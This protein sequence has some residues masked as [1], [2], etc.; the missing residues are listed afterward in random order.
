[1]YKI[2]RNN[3][4]YHCDKSELDLIDGCIRNDVQAQKDLYYKYCNQMFTLVYRILNDYDDANDALQEAFVKVFK[5]INK[6]RKESTLGAWIKTIVIR[7]ALQK[8]KNAN[9]FISINDTGNWSIPIVWPNTLTGMDL[10]RAIK[11]LPTGYRTIFSLIE[12]EGYSHKEVAELLNI[13]IG[14]SKS[15]LHGAKKKLQVKLKEFNN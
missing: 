12:I 7:T 14:T 9:S 4:K 3:L 13:S 5:N 2:N 10:K 15:Q 1:M 11:E 8:I 6:F